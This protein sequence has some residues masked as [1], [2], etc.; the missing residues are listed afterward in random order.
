MLFVHNNRYLPLT[1][2]LTFLQWTIQPARNISWNISRQKIHEIL[3]HYVLL[4]L[5]TL[6]GLYCS[7]NY[8]R[9]RLARVKVLTLSQSVSKSIN[10]SINQHLHSAVCRERIRGAWNKY[11]P[12][13]YEA[14]LHGSLKEA[15]RNLWRSY[16]PLHPLEVAPSMSF[17][18]VSGIMHYAWILVYTRVL[19]AM[20]MT[21]DS[22]AIS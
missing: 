1:G 10:Q 3:H 13:D 11:T 15:V 18:H 20:L 6:L 16:C 17:I 12:A 9:R 8:L 4:V 22:A 2:L 21:R 19:C 14:K 5:F 7:F